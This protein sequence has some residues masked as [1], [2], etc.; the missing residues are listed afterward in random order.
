MLEAG[1]SSSYHIAK[2]FGLTERVA[3][4][5]AEKPAKKAAKPAAKVA[6]NGFATP[7]IPPVPMPDFTEAFDP[8]AIMQT[9]AERKR[10]RA[11]REE[12]RDEEREEPRRRSIDVGRV[13]TRALT[14]AGL[15]K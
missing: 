5:G 14:A 8:L 10:A 13:I 11:E 12:A 2:F 15:M 3:E 4:T 1:I 7:I 6:V 9:R